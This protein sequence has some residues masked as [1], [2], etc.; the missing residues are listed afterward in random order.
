MLQVPQLI[1]LKQLLIFYGSKLSK[2]Y[3]I[4]FEVN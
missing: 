1:Q 4:E 2:K 3:T